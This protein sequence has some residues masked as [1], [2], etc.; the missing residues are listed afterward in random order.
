VRLNNATL[1]NAASGVLELQQ[2]SISRYSGTPTL[3]NDGL[4]TKVS[5]NSATLYGLV[6]TGTGRVQVQEGAL[7]WNSCTL[8]NATVQVEQGTLYWNGGVAGN[9]QIAAGSGAVAVNGDVS[10]ATECDADGAHREVGCVWLSGDWADGIWGAVG[11]RGHFGV[12]KRRCPVFWWHSG[13]SGHL[14]QDD[15]YQVRLT[16]PPC[17]TRQAACW[18]CSG[19]GFVSLWN[20][21]LAKRRADQK[22]VV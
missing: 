5:S 9:A 13:Q 12:G 11:E 1:R 15:G 6:I 16:T 3:Q 8:S 17:A 18:S 20:P 4:I 14:A 21:H 10:L 19:V 2:G 22:G 7:S